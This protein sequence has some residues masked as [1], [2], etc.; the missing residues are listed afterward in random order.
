M[1]SKVQNFFFVP[2]LPTSQGCDL[3]PNFGD[4]NQSEKL[5]EVIPPLIIL[6]DQIQPIEQ[7]LRHI[8]H[9]EAPLE[10]G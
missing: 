8:L 6:A 1:K 3:A 9:A 5:S 2:V 10:G 7:K 4:L